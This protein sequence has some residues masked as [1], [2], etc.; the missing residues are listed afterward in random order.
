ML[1][2]TRS[3]FTVKLS[4]VQDIQRAIIRLG[5]ELEVARLESSEAMRL[6]FTQSIEREMSEL[7]DEVQTIYDELPEVAVGQTYSDYLK[8]RV[9]GE[10]V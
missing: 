4:E 10:L 2:L 7:M 3:E 5:R 1:L 9:S 8:A 6:F